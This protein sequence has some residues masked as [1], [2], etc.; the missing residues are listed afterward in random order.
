MDKYNYDDIAKLSLMDKA[1]HALATS[2]P[3]AKELKTATHRKGGTLH[4]KILA[5]AFLGMSQLLS[6]YAEFYQEAVRERDSK[7]EAE[8][9]PVPGSEDK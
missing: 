4:D 8:I 1:V 5:T 6:K 2:N 9:P 7:A 3:I